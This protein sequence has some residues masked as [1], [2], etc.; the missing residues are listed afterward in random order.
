ME[1]R[2]STTVD[3][4]PYLR[5]LS[6]LGRKYGVGLTGDIT[7]F[8]MKPPEDHQHDYVCDADGRISFG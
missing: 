8:V 3:L 7:V 6:E 2:T 5:E 4:N 1:D